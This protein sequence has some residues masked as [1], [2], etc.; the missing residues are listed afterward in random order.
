MAPK[1]RQLSPLGPRYQRPAQVRP[2]RWKL[3][4]R[5]SAAPM[6]QEHSRSALWLAQQAQACS[7]WVL[8]RARPMA[9]ARSRLVPSRSAQA[10][11]SSELL[12]ALPVP[13]P[14]RS[15]R[16]P[17]GLGRVQRMVVWRLVRVRLAQ[18]GRLRLR[19]R[20]ASE[21][22]REACC[23]HV[24]CLQ[25]IPQDWP[26]AS[27][28]CVR[29]HARADNRACCASACLGE[30]SRAE[31]ALPL[32]AAPIQWRDRA[33]ILVGERVLSGSGVASPRA[34]SRGR[35]FG[36]ARRG[37]AVHQSSLRERA[38][39]DFGEVELGSAVGATTSCEQEAGLFLAGGCR[40]EE[41]NL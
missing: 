12:L 9:Q 27:G 14:A 3:R 1:R 38:R 41:L 37:G 32:T 18:V 13:V 28:Q 24:S 40:R 29:A 20:S 25:T 35:A 5:C 11:S 30:T 17:M 23:E 8:L 10:C 7:R 31:V 33:Q 19:S 34:G 16:S 4:A 6:Q 39:S 21:R 2:T 15:V 22:T 26:N 36:R